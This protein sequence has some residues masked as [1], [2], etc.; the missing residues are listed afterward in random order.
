MNQP[1]NHT[2]PGFAEAVQRFDRFPAELKALPNWCVAAPDKTPYTFTAEAGFIEAKSTQPEHWLTF[3]DAIA[4]MLRSKASG[5]GFM[6][7]ASDGY[8]CIDLDVKNQENCPDKPEEWTT[9]QNAE[10][11]YKITQAFDSYTERSRSGYGAHIWV[12]GYIG[13]GAKRDGVEVYCQERFMI[14]TGDMFIDKPVEDR[15]EL[16]DVLIAEIRKGQNNTRDV[17][18]EDAPET[19]TDAVVYERAASAGNADKFLQ[20]MNGQ[21]QGTWKSQSEADL[22]LMS[23]LA[24]YSKSNAQCRRMFRVSGLGQR[25]KATKND[26][27]L[28]YCLEVIRS[29]Q[30]KE[31]AMDAQQEA[32]ARQLVAQLQSGS[33]YE[34]IAAAQIAMSKTDEEEGVTP[35]AETEAALAEGHMEAKQ[36]DWPPGMVGHIAKFVFTAA[37]R[38]VREIAIVTA[39]GFMAGV[40]GKAFNL[41]SGTGLN[42]YMVLIARSGVGKETLHTGTS[43]LC[44][45]LR[46]A[47]PAAQAFVDFTEFASGPSLIKA[48]AKNPSFVNV[49]GEWGRR[50]QRMANDDRGEGPMG[51][52]RTQMTHLYQKSGQG[53]LVGGIAYSNEENNV[54][55]TAGVAYSLVG[56]TTPETFYRSLT[57]SMMEDGFMSRFLLVEYKGARPPANRGRNK[58]MIPELR[59]ALASMCAQAMAN[60]ARNHAELVEASPEAQQLLDRFDTTCDKKIDSTHNEA[61]RQM[62]NRAH[63][64]VSRVAAILACADNWMQPVIQLCHAEWALSVVM[65]DINT[66]SA[67]LQSGDVGNGDD[68]TR[69]LKVMSVVREFFTSTKDYAS[70]YGLNPLMKDHGVIPH[71]FLQIRCT[72]LAQFRN[73]RTGAKLALDNTIK[74]LIDNGYIG[75]APRDKLLEHYAY[76]GKAY[77]VISYPRELID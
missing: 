27:H 55:M 73:A 33:K 53:N 5:V 42:L 64:K 56:E 1:V 59:Q 57:E 35:T 6:L 14:C 62:W 10:R 25:E 19:E 63:L 32:M 4:L 37:P 40:C 77:R 71:R 18:L 8:S 20:L 60:N 70:T 52:L 68:H 21:W 74:S 17:L 58:E 36:L 66:M 28:N 49:S 23:M 34:D 24:F 67:R 47:N 11:F 72:Q 16:L 39:L 7:H 12:K 30:H 46:E 22:A 50:L 69:F 29:R 54:G 38:P 2:P 9:P 48:C 61:I 76:S 26:R 65:Q 45:A 31:A 41:K 15:Q 75:E 3:H 43:A 51:T 13:V 44:S